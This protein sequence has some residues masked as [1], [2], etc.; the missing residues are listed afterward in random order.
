MHCLLYPENQERPNTG[1]SSCAVSVAIA[2]VN[3]CEW[4]APE[5]M[6]GFLERCNEYAMIG[7]PRWA[8]ADTR[9][10]QSG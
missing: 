9:D 8:E 10:K 3:M 2:V 7:L 4:S 6:E 1:S 5:V